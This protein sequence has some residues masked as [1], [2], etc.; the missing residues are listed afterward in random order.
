MDEP[1]LKVMLWKRV[2]ESRAHICNRTVALA[3]LVQDG[4]VKGAIC[5][6]KKEEGLLCY[7]A[8]AV[9]MANGG[10]GRFG[11][12][13]S[14]YL[15]GTFDY[16]GNAGDGYSLGLRAGAHLTGME[17][18]HTHTPVKGI[19]TP[20]LYI[21]LTRGARLVNALGEV[22]AEGDCAVT[23]QRRMAEARRAGPLFVA[24]DH[25][26]EEKIQEIEHVLFTTER[27]LQRRYWL[28]KGLNFRRDP[29]ELT[30]S[31]PQ[32]CGGHGASGF[33][34]NENAETSL[35]GLYAAGDAAAVPFQHL[36]GAFVFG[37]VAAESALAYMEKTVPKKMSAAKPVQR[38]AETIAALR[39]NGT[40]P[41]SGGRSTNIWFHR[42]ISGNYSWR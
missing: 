11:L 41:V 31:E 4:V 22:L 12:P 9:I 38:V 30:L 37:R 3:L 8:K 27:P 7:H 25:L 42:K 20:L 19:N 13:D 6:D 32:L 40:A 5:L 34:V 21:T 17:Y 2:D 1:D 16:P 23:S 24:M 33:V 15:F 18:V 35:S 29:I 28:E 39:A 14:G 10:A 36:S 26:P